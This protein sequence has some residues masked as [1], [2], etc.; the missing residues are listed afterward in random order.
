MTEIVFYGR[1]GQ[2]VVIAS[3][4]LAAAAFKEG[5][6]VQSFPFFGVERRG[7]PV[8]AYTRIDNT[9]I[10]RR[11]PIKK[12]DY[13]I[14]FD[15][16][17]IENADAAGGLKENGVILINSGSARRNFPLSKKTNAFLFDASAVALRHGLGSKNSPIVNTPILGAFVKITKEIGIEA[18][19]EAIR[20]NI[21]IR[22]E[23]NVNAAREAYEKAK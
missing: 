2:G 13:I 21:S 6:S 5:K 4:V 7:A 15:P 9:K 1:G 23:D 12:S 11:S 8:T 14:V 10:R 16:M 19:I 17:L 3:R 20:E 22:T 18:L